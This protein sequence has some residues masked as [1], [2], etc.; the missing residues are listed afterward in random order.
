MG[1]FARSVWPVM[2]YF[3]RSVWAVMGYFAH[4]VWPVMGYFA[5]SVWPVMGYFARSVWPVMGYFAHCLGPLVSICNLKDPLHYSHWASRDCHGWLL[6]SCARNTA[7]VLDISEVLPCGS[8]PWTVQQNKHN[9]HWDGDCCQSHKQLTH[10]LH[11]NTGSNMQCMHAQHLHIVQTDGGEEQCCL[12]EIYHNR[13]IMGG[14]V[15]GREKEG[16]SV[17]ALFQTAKADRW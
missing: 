11:T 13:N 9:A 12:P 7:T 2:G 15:G 10:D 16:Y 1:Y 5:R 17:L 14:W 8:E 6:F 3:A 4:S